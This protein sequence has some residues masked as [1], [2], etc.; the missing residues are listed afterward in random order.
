MQI[1][2]MLDRCERLEQR[3]AALYRGFASSTRE[4]PRLC[5]LW[6]DLAREEEEH[7]RSIAA[8]R[9]RL[10]MKGEWRMWLDGWEEALA[11]VE[12]RLGAAERLGPGATDVQQLT[13]ALDL[14]MTELEAF[15][16]VLLAAART[17]DPG[18]PERHAE[19]LADAAERLT[20]DPQVRLQAAL[21]RARVR[22]HASG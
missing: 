19:L 5:A 11:G 13:A 3:A 7:A 14:E 4:E 10:R 22:V 2:A 20:D 18:A 15:R 8:A 21:L 16:R 12:E 17:P 9:A 1:E 6:T